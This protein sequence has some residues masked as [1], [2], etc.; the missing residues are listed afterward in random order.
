MAEAYVAPEWSPIDMLQR[1]WEKALPHLLL[2]GAVTLAIF[3]IQFGIGL[4]F[5][6]LEGVVSG[7]AEAVAR[8]RGGD[9][10][11][12]VAAMVRLVM[13]LGRTCITLPITMITTG[14]MARLALSAARGETPDLGAFSLSLSKFFRILF[15][16]FVVGFA[17]LVGMAFCII[18]GII[19]AIALQFFIFAIMDTELGIIASVQYSWNLTKDHLLNLGIFSLL[20]MGVALVAVCG[21]CGLGMVVFQPIALVAQALIYIH[22]S[23]RTQDF[24]PDPEVV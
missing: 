4:V 12:I 11:Q 3:V 1:A 5:G 9:S 2:L 15:A 17:T 20:I 18:P 22:L 8:D 24:L 16:S 13:S 6:I 7:I 21:T 10:A 23:G 14:A 19:V